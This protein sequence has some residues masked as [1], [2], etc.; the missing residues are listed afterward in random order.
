M[1]IKSTKQDWNTL[2]EDVK[3]NARAVREYI[4]SAPGTLQGQEP[5]LAKEFLNN[6]RKAYEKLE[7]TGMSIQ[8]VIQT[9]DG[10]VPFAGQ[11]LRG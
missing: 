1:A 6:A 9:I 7:E 2:L 8:N 10:Q 3:S 11:P 4:D 5:A